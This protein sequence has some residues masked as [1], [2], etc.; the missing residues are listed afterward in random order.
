MKKFLIIGANSDIAFE[1]CKILAKEKNELLLASR[2]MSNL[3]KKRDEI[4]N[5]YN[6]NCNAL[7][8]DMEKF[9]SFEKF[10]D[11]LD[12]DVTNIIIASG[13]QEIPE[14]NKE[15]I[16]NINY[17]GPKKFIQKIIENKN[18]SNIEQ[19]I[20]I[21]SVAADRKNLIKNTYALSKKKFS[22]FLYE[23]HTKNKTISI[24]NIKP[25]YVN[26]K[27]IKN[28]KLNKFLVSEAKD[29]ANKI[30]LCLSYNKHEFYLPNYWKILLKFYNFLTGFYR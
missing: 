18:F 7:F 20:A 19:I 23:L 15:K 13:Y 25:G 14:I 3:F 29:I 10:L 2:D 6:T 11:D 28:L 30:F 4:L 22:D 12:N 17:Y 9:H 26:T 24:K 27:M 21:T 5:I 1:L 16:L 8:L